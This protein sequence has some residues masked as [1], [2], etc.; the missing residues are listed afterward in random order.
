MRYVRYR[1]SRRSRTFD[2][3]H[4]LRTL[5]ELKKKQDGAGGEAVAI[6]QILQ[7]KLLASVQAE[8]KAQVQIRR[9][10]EKL[11]TMGGEEGDDKEAEVPLRFFTPCST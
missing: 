2:T 7:M 3:L 10:Q 6:I 9:L 1:S 8:D 11:D 4:A 5:Q